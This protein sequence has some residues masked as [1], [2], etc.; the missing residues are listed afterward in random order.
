MLNKYKKTSPNQHT[1]LLIC[2]L[3]VE[4][5]P[6]KSLWMICCYRIRNVHT[7]TDNQHVLANQKEDFNNAVVRIG[8][9]HYMKPHFAHVH[10]ENKFRTEIIT[11]DV[12]W[13]VLLQCFYS[14]GITCIHKEEN[15]KHYHSSVFSGALKGTANLTPETPSVKFFPR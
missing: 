10:I 9:F 5:P 6:Y 7:V 15:L 12:D 1:H 3:S 8:T 11:T 14:S 4:R 2:L 13:N